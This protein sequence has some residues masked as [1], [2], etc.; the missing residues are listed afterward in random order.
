[1][2]TLNIIP[3]NYDGNPRDALGYCWQDFEKKI[4]GED[5]ILNGVNW[6]DYLKSRYGDNIEVHN[7]NQYGFLKTVPGKI[8]TSVNCMWCGGFSG[9]VYLPDPEV[10]IPTDTISQAGGTIEE[11]SAQ[12]AI[13]EKIELMEKDD[14][15]ID[16]PGYCTKCH[17]FCYG[18][19]EAN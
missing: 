14:R 5:V 19:C 9:V 15:N 10:D 8:V 17:S 12:V 3:S 1:M 13:S 18:D 11:T 2:E 6:K 4:P 7:H 16:H